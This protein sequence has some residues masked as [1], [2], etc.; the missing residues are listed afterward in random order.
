[1][2]TSIHAAGPTGQRSPGLNAAIAAWHAE[3]P[4]T[5]GSGGT[6]TAT[7][8]PEAP[9]EGTSASY[10]VS[11]AV[12]WPAGL[13]WSTDP[14]GG[15][16]P[17]ISGTALVSL[18]TVSGVTRAVMG[19]TFPAVGPDP[20][21]DITP[22][23]AGSMAVTDITGTGFTATITGA[24]DVGGLNAAPYAFSTD[25]GATWTAYQASNVYVADTLAPSTTYQVTWRVRDAV[26]LVTNGTPQAVT[27]SAAVAS[28]PVS[29]TYLTSATGAG[30]DA[31]TPQTF[32]DVGI[33]T[34]SATRTVI[35][36]VALSGSSNYASATS[37]S[38]GGVS[39]TKDIGLS[40]VVSG[41]IS[42]WRAT[43]PVGATAD[44]I[45]G[46]DRA[47]TASY[48]GVWWSAS[49]AVPIDTASAASGDLSLDT[50]AGSAI[51]AAILPT[52]ATIGWSASVAERW[53]TTGK[54]SGADGSGTGSAVTISTSSPGAKVAVSY[55]AY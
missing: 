43:V 29:V 11:S 50:I 36:A 14:D 42:I 41:G 45:V 24:S 19:A 10:L 27:T 46:C 55:A 34:A 13:V 54:L 17:A 9:A 40:S 33:G 39:A 30:G 25:N 53:N 31:V 32:A 2:P 3:N 48:V 18:F 4:D 26:G 38:I 1:M 12:T 21:P 5:G 35:V 20:D 28:N 22:P 51:V 23:T 6:I 44:I 47:F 37:V 16:E 52:N 7:N 49:A 15:T 8:A